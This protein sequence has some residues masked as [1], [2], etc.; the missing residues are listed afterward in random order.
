MKKEYDYEHMY[1]IETISEL[2]MGVIAKLITFLCTKKID[3]KR[4]N[5]FFAI[6]YQQ[7]KMMHNLDLFDL[8]EKELKY[9]SEYWDKMNKLVDKIKKDSEI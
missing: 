7:F 6:L 2:S 9:V 4:S 1:N 5:D 3:I 8:N